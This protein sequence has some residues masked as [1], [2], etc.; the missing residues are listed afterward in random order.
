MKKII[1]NFLF[2]RRFKVLKNK[3][4]FS[5]VEILVAVSIIGLSEQ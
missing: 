5:L 1:K 4:G 2:K 3:K